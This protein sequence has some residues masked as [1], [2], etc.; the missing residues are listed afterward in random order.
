[1]DEKDLKVFAGFTNITSKTELAERLFSELAG[2]SIF[3]LQALSAFV[4]KDIIAL[5][6]PYRERVRPYFLEQYFHRFGHIM[7]MRQQGHFTGLGPDIKDIALFKDFCSKIAE[8]CPSTEDLEMFGPSFGHYYFTLSAFYIFV[9]D[10][11]GHPVGTPFPGGFSVKKRD[12][13]IYCPIRDKEKDVTYSICNFC[14][15]KQEKMPGT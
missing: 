10:E 13:G 9:L 7:A 12:D 3:D 11:P 5:P 2:Y 14:P 8:F 6:S 15:A 1:M 4:E